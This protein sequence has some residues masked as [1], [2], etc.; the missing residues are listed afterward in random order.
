MQGGGGVGGGCNFEKEISKRFDS[1][2]ISKENIC[3]SVCL[4]RD[5]SPSPMV[6]LLFRT[7]SKPMSAEAGLIERSKR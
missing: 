6:R 2:G 7:F 1:F 5:V 4:Q 3:G